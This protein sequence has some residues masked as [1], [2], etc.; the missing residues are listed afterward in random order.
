MSDF[1]RMID[2]DSYSRYE[3][4]E[5]A[6]AFGTSGQQK[7]FNKVKEIVNKGS[8]TSLDKRPLI[9]ISDKVQK[10]KVINRYLIQ[11]IDYEN[12][13]KKLKDGGQTAYSALIG[14]KTVCS[15]Y[16][17]AF[18][19][20]ANASGVETYIVGGTGN[21]TGKFEPHSWN[22]SKL[23]NY[24]YSIDV[25]WNDSFNAETRWFLLG[26]TNINKDHRPDPA[27]F[28]TPGTKL[29]KREPG[30]PPAILYTC[31]VCPRPIN[32]RRFPTTAG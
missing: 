22:I 12:N 14:R 10:L 3:W 28:K 19:L 17:H 7:V 2:K 11:T 24:Y 6:K 8:L 5:I 9:D 15:G 18:S 13:Y 29:A 27:N 30:L 21:A 4:N 23:G 20:L 25:T 1:V 16:A 32:R 31:R 26:K